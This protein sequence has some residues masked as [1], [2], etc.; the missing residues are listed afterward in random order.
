MV[1][2]STRMPQVSQAV[3]EFFGSEPLTNSTRQV[4][5][6]GAAIQANLL[7]GNNVPPATCCCWT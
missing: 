1:G 3:A 2:G 4:V 7:A 6:L 5:A